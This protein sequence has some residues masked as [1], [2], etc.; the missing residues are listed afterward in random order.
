MMHSIMSLIE[1][2]DYGQN[3]SVRLKFKSQSQ[4][5]IWDV[6]IDA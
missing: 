3:N 4:I 2:T 5:N 1:D 6:D